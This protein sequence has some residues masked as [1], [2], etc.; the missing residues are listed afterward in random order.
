MK[1]KNEKKIPMSHCNPFSLSPVSWHV[2]FNSKTMMN[3]NR[4]A[5]VI[6]D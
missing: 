5:D 6:Q 4:K 2:C 3:R 1:E